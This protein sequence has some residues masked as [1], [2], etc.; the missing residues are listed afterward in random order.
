MWTMLKA[1][2]IPVALAILS[3]ACPTEFSLYLGTVRL[4]VHRIVLIFFMFPALFKLF[5]PRQMRLSSYDVLFLGYNVWTVAVFCMHLGTA[6]GLQFGGALAV[7]SFGGYI[8]ARAYI[9]D[10]AQFR[11]CLMFLIFTMLIVAA[12]AFPEAI[13]G[14]I[15]I[16][17]F[18]F[19]LTG[20]YHPT[21]VET[22]LGLTRAYSTFDHPI[23]YGSFCASMLS[24]MWFTGT[25]WFSRSARAGLVIGCT[26]LGLSSAPLLVLG[27]QIAII[28]WDKLTRTYQRR[29]TYTLIGCVIFYFT[30]DFLSN[31]P[32]YV[33]ILTRVTLDP[34]TA[35]YRIQIWTYGS[36][37]VENYPWF[38]I[39]LNDWERPAWMYSSSVDAFWLLIPMRVG[40]PATVM[41]LGGIWMLLRNVHFKR[42]RPF[43]RLEK[44]IA[45]G[46]TISFL[47]IAI[48]G[49][50]VHYWNSLYAYFFFLIGMGGWL[51][52][53]K[54]LKAVAKAVTG[55]FRAGQAARA[56]PKLRGRWTEVPA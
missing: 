19:T 34:W 15:I 25:T 32:A 22:R 51:A 5:Q 16:H 47:A 14:R 41:L 42:R 8:V 28:G 17:D 45:I 56:K 29:V 11:A 53:A 20:Y 38:G 33:A 30:L 13:S 55:E 46:W 48:A 1:T 2:P 43:T 37:T 3:F 49:G 39:G 7:E 31:R 21:G 12:L 26:F 10:Y 35:F 27:L 54:P 6:D 36:V 9:R 23:L 52:D 40:L 4:P 18:L 44:E 50:T 24:M